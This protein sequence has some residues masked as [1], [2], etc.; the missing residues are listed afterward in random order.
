MAIPSASPTKMSAR[1]AISGRS[2]TV[3]IAA[4]PTMPTAMAPAM[5]LMPTEAAAV[6]K[7]HFATSGSTPWR[8]PASWAESTNGESTIREIH[9]R[10]NPPITSQS[11]ALRIS[12]PFSHLSRL[13]WVEDLYISCASRGRENLALHLCD[14]LLRYPAGDEGGVTYMAKVSSRCQQ[15]ERHLGLPLQHRE[16]MV[17]LRGS[18]S[19]GRLQRL[20]LRSGLGLCL[21]CLT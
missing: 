1:V 10:K 2:P 19:E 8:T 12:P 17:G 3:P 15:S 4:A 9:V 14:L 6:R 20:Q 7:P 5:V 13:F 16:S 18:L 11:V 21:F